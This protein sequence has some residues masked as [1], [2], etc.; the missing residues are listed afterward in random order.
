[1]NK[2]TKQAFLARFWETCAFSCM[3]FPLSN[4]CVNHQSEKGGFTAV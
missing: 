1:M 4:K 3:G 2:T